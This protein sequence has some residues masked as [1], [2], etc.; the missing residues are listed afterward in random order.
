MFDVITK[1]VVKITY[2]K[3]IVGLFAALGVD[4]SLTD[5]SSTM[6]E[7]SVTVVKFIVLKVDASFVSK[8]YYYNIESVSK[9][10][11]SVYEIFDDY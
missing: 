10:I 5:D 1:R 6:D 9:I 3:V 7:T 11:S 8:T 2:S 4:D